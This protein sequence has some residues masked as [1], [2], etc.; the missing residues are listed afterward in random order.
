[1]AITGLLVL[2]LL[3]ILA[4][5]TRLGSVLLDRHYP[6]TGA[7]IEAGG[8]R[9][10]VIDRG[11][12]SSEAIVLIHGASSNALDVDRAMGG[13]LAQRFRVV[14]IDR[15]GHGHSERGVDM[16]TPAAQARLLRTALRR[17]GVERAVLVGHSYGT[18]VA[19]A[20]A[21]EEPVLAIG[22]VLI[23]PATHP[24]PGGGISWHNR[25]AAVPFA[26]P[27]F[28]AFF[29]LP[30]GWLVM[31]NAVT[32]S[33]RPD[34]APENYSKASAIPLILRPATFVANAKDLVSLLPAVKEMQPNYGRLPR[35]MLVI[36]GTTDPVVA[37]SI[38][39]EGMVRDAPGARVLWLEGVGHMPHWSRFSGQV[40]EAIA[41]E[42]RTHLS[43]TVQPAP[44]PSGLPS[45]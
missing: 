3:F 41:E 12:R 33:F 1:M 37:P 29:T 7:F 4:V 22:M 26:G 23:A 39:T 15:P 13:P 38:H 5:A 36:S 31:D 20:L 10:H 8:L 19:A 21:L 35:G 40:I 34:P 17:V 42:A 11:P 44:V 2:G 25:L 14:S 32:G 27:A 43:G 16:D 9:L 18:A 24:W 28:T 45:R 6:P 30:L